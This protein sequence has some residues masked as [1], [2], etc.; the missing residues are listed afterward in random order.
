MGYDIRAINGQIQVEGGGVQNYDLV[1]P[2]AGEL[3]ILKKFMT[4]LLNSQSG[5]S[6]SYTLALVYK[7]ASGESITLFGPT[8]FAANGAEDQYRTWYQATP[9]AFSTANDNT[10]KNMK[11]TILGV[12]DKI[13]L[14]VSVFTGTGTTGGLTFNY[15][16]YGAYKS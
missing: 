8:A 6:A 5:G 10:Y 14:Q 7:P 2:A 13:Q 4:H 9:A 1:A 3:F 16:L 11:D 12:G 15:N